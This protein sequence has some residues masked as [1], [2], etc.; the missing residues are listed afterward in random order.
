[1][2]MP[3]PMPPPTLPAD[4]RYR[5]IRRGI[6]MQ[7]DVRLQDVIPL[8]I[9]RGIVLALADNQHHSCTPLQRPV[10]AGYCRACDLINLARTYSTPLEAG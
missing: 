10:P 1:M 5:A 9:P 6:T 7:Y 4:A 8:R 2:T 3:P